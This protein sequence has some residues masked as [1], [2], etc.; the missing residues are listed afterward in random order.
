MELKDLSKEVIELI[1]DAKTS[2]INFITEQAEDVI[3]LAAKGRVVEANNLL[4]DLQD[5][6]N[7]V[8][9]MIKLHRDIWADTEA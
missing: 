6:Q 7:L 5:Y 1:P 2:T 4:T 9:T 8:A 3:R